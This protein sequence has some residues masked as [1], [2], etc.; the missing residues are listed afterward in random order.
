ME[1]V[2]ARAIS[3]LESAWKSLV[4]EDLFLANT[5]L[6]ETFRERLSNY[7]L[8]LLH[9]GFDAW[10]FRASALFLDRVLV[11]IRLSLCDLLNSGLLCHLLFPFLRHHDWVDIDALGN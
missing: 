1:L 3:K 5:F 9:R 11:S 7:F 4:L 10:I 2:D 6:R 8:E